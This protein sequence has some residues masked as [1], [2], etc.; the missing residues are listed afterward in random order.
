[1]RIEPEGPNYVSFGMPRRLEQ[2]ATENLL[3]IK[4]CVSLGLLAC[5][6]QVE[7]GQV[8]MG[9]VRLFSLC[10]GVQGSCRTFQAVCAD[11]RMQPS[12]GLSP[13]PSGVRAQC[14]TQKSNRDYPGAALAAGHLS[15][16]G[17]MDG[18]GVLVCR[19]S[20]VPLS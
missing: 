18:L 8:E 7:H 3:M 10:T 12:A 9:D 2:E 20:G 13:C 11:V 4:T 19:T 16:S 14:V 17:E 1:M 15:L 6:G 5:V